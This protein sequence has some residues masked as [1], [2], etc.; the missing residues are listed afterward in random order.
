MKVSGIVL[1]GGKSSRMGT[2]KASLMYHGKTLIQNALD[3][4]SPF[5]TEIL[6]SSNGHEHDALGYAVVADEIPD[7]GTIGGIY[8]CLKQIHHDVCV[9][10]P[11]DTPFVN[12]GLLLFLLDNCDGYKATFPR[13]AEGLIE[14]LVAL[15]TKNALS[16]IEEAL[17]VGDYKVQNLVSRLHG[18]VIDIH[19]GLNF[20]TPDLFR[21]V[22]TP[23]D[24]F[25]IGE[26]VHNS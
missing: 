6:I 25:S 15:Y 9:T 11:C 13:S 4:L 21:N 16:G 1:A 24:Y 17:T 3:I 26:G 14:P 8:S 18:N 10:L 12:T 23:D 7:I 5:C 20:Y 22:N 2:D 19:S